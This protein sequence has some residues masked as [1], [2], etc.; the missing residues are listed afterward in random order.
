MITQILIEIGV[1]EEGPNVTEYSVNVPWTS[2][3]IKPNIFMGHNLSR[4]EGNVHVFGRV[5]ILAIVSH[6]YE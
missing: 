3:L 4:I 5:F 2:M 6:Y 1:L